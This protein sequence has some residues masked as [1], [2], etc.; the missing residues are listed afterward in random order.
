MEGQVMNTVTFGNKNSYTD[1]SLILKERTISFPQAKTM[2]VDVV[3]MNGVLDLTE[4]L[5]TVKYNRRSITMTFTLV[6]RTKFLSTL[7]D[8]ANYIHGQNMEVTFSDDD[9]F[10]YKGRCSLNSFQT[11]EATGE[12][13]VNM[14]AYPYKLERNLYEDWLWD[15]FDF[16]TGIIIDRSFTITDS[17]TITLINRRMES[18][19]SFRANSAMTLGFGG[20]TF[21]LPA[22][23]TKKFYDI[24]L[25]EGDNT[26][27]VTG[28]GTLTIDYELGDL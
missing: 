28:T 18:V 9:N 21:E 16:E 22:N 5:G 24:V 14:D 7:T 10:Y 26:L 25:T 6:D 8:F 4:T 20:H 19:P 23:K 12:I 15:D 17:E 3:G 1:F 13:V 2:M 11:G 27:T